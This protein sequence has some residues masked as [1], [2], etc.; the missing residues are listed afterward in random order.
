MKLVSLV[1]SVLKNQMGLMMIALVS[2]MTY[3]SC[4]DRSFI[5]SS[6]VMLRFSMDTIRFDTVF[7][8]LGSATR[9]VKIFNDYDES[10]LISNISLASPNSFFRLNIDGISSNEMDNVEILPYDSLWVF[11]EVTINPDNP[12]SVSPFVIDDQILF[13]TNGNAQHVQLEAFGQNANYIPNRFA[14]GTIDTLSTICNGDTTR[15]NDPK[16]YVL[17]GLYY[18]RDCNLVLEKG[19][20]LYVHGGVANNDFGIYSDGLMLIGPDASLTLRGTPDEPVVIQGDRLETEFEDV[21]GQWPGIRI[22]NGSTGNKFTNAIIKNSIIGVEVDSAATLSLRSCEISNTSSSGL[23]GVHA[24]IDAVNC[25]FHS[26]GSNAMQVVYGGTYNMDYCTFANYGNQGAAVGMTNYICDDPACVFGIRDVYPLNAKFKNSIL[27]GSAK[28]ELI[29]S[30]GTFGE[31][32]GFYNYYFDH[33]IVKV[34]ELLDPGN[35]PNFFENTSNCINMDL[36][37]PLF[38]DINTNDYHLDT[39]SIARGMG[40]SISGVNRDLDNVIRDNSMPDIG[41]YEF[42][43]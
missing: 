19:T 20:K 2:M 24:E 5:E 39:L 37:D 3:Q 43:E 30:D 42:V 25:L 35:F 33:C 13:N 40:S 26:N 32:P 4:R 23:I 38:F 14:A 18:V 8:E 28:D 15:W 6:D 17:Y 36:Q 16:P 22:L 12:L 7:T 1:K 41:C 29:L 31:I 9:Y 27:A 34:D 21:A 10:V 11:A